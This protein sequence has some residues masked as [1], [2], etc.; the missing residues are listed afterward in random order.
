MSLTTEIFETLR[1]VQGT[2]Y[3]MI[4]IKIVNDQAKHAIG[5]QI[6][7]MR[8]VTEDGTSIS[9]FDL[10]L[11]FDQKEFIGYFTTDAFS[12]ITGTVDIV[13]GYGDDILETIESININAPGVIAGLPPLLSSQSYQ[14][15][16]NFW[17][18]N[19]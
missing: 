3:R 12:G 4:V 18:S 10:Y 16:N 11:T 6:E 7:F 9:P 15:A 8:V 19:L 14:N 1:D 17:L 5:S 2:S 13:F